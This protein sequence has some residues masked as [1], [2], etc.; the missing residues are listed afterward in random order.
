M[1]SA[2]SPPGPTQC[3][4]YVRLP[5]SSR[6]G[7]WVRRCPSLIR[8]GLRAAERDHLLQALQTLA[9]LLPRR[10]QGFVVPA[11]G[12]GRLPDPLP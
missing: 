5:S 12:F 7:F 9:H 2:R 3:R 4:E 1:L 8:T 6:I 11:T 10:A